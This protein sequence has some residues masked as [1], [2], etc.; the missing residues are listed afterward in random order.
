MTEDRS[1]CCTQ[2]A[3]CKTAA[4]DAQP[5]I[6][7]SA[8]AIPRRWSPLIGGTFQMG[9]AEKGFVEDGEGPVRP[10]TLSPFAIACHAVSNLQFGDFV[11]ATG[12]TTEAERYG[13]SFVFDGLLPDEA[14]GASANRVRA[15]PW[16][17]A[18][19]RAYWAQPEGPVSCILDRL[20]HPA[21]HVSWN[22]AQ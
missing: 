18:V 3:A 21:V 10:V 12:Y 9:S 16:W 17:V 13:W 22:D 14:R 15:T 2:G 11:R 6:V 7:P 8:T 4:T 20:D 1:H 19:P 5:A